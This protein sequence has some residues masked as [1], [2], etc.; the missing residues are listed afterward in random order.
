MRDGDL[1]VGLIP[2]MLQGQW[3]FRRLLFISG[4]DQ[5]DLLAREGWED[6]VCKA[7]V[8][9]LRQLDSWRV[10]DLRDL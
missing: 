1:L 9:A 5:L 8:R 3:G 2:L 6:E 4:D 10:A 7:G